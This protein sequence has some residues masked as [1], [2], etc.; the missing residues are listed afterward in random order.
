[1]G[2]KQHAV[3]RRMVLFHHQQQLQLQV[4]DCSR[5]IGR[6]DIPSLEDVSCT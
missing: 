5:H 6:Y 1:M 3:Q 4:I 2:Y